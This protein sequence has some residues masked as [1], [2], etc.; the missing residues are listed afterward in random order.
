MEEPTIAAG[1]SVWV[2][3]GAALAVNVLTSLIKNVNWT[4][5]AKNLVATVLSIVAAAAATI[6][7]GDFEAKPLFELSVYIYGLAQAFYALILK[8]TVINHNLE[9]AVNAPEPRAADH[10]DDA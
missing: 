9:V 2:V 3:L 10:L 4:A 1:L 7:A 5:R 6:V 8:G